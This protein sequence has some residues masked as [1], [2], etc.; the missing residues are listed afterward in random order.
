[1]TACAVTGRAPHGGGSHNLGMLMMR[2]Q[3]SHLLQNVLT[4]QS[5]PPLREVPL[6]YNVCAVSPGEQNLACPG[7]ERVQLAMKASKGLHAC[8]PVWARRHLYPSAQ[9]TN[10]AERDQTKG[11]AGMP[12]K[13]AGRRV[14]DYDRMRCMR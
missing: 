12:W 13:E 2:E 7:I 11:Q 9:C 3:V 14:D 6:A 4:W 5:S 10:A 1:M 8:A